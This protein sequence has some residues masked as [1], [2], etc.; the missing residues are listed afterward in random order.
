MDLGVR[1]AIELIMALVFILIL[2]YLLSKVIKEKKTFLSL[3]YVLLMVLIINSSYH[4]Y[5][6]LTSLRIFEADQVEITSLIKDKIIEVDAGVLL[7]GITGH[8]SYGMINMNF[9]SDYRI[10]FYKEN[11]ILST[12][13]IKTINKDEVADSD[14]IFRVLNRKYAIMQIGNR[15]YSLKQDFYDNLK[16]IM[17]AH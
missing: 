10:N 4:R 13:Y 16:S 6:T 12:A 7:E 3:V 11:K 2:A 8:I 9:S 5:H 17:Q 14:H 15:Y 1:I